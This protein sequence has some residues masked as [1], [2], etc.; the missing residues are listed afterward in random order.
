MLFVAL[1]VYAQEA[2]FNPAGKVEYTGG[3][4]TSTETIVA[5]WTTR[6]ASPNALSRSCVAYVTMGGS[7]YIYQ[8]G[9]GATTQL[10][11]VARYDVAANTWLNTG[12]ASIPFSMSS[13]AAVPVGDSSI[14]L[15]GGE[16]T[17]GLGKTCKYN[18]YTNTWTTMANMP[19]AVT[20]AAVV[21]WGTTK[22][23][24]IGGGTGLFGT[25]Y[26]NTVQVYDIATD[27]Y[28][29][30]GTYPVIAGMMGFGIYKD[31][32]YCAGGWDGAAAI[33]NA[34]KGVINPT[35]FQV[36]WTPLPNYPAGTCTRIAS[37]FV[38]KNT[39]GGILF[40]GGAIA[41]STVT[42]N[43]YLWDIC[44]GN[45]AT[46][47][48]LPLARSNMKAAG[49]GDS[50]A[51]VVC[52]YTTVGVGNNDRI[53][54]S[55]IDG[56]CITGGVAGALNPFNLQ[57]P[58]AGTTITTLPGSTT[59]VTSTWD[60]STAL[61]TYKWIFGSPTVPPR[62]FTVSAAT[63]MW[64]TTLGA[65]DAI[66]A[67]A[68]VNQGDSLIGQ[69]DVWA[70]RNNPPANDSLKAAN[71]PRA[72]I[73]KRARPALVAFNLV[74][75]ASGT[76]IVTSPF[77]SSMVSFLWRK[78]GA[79]VTYRWKFGSPTIGTV[80][81]NTLSNSSGFDTSLAGRKL[82]IDAILAGIGVSPGGSIAGQWAVWAYSGSDSLRSA[83]VFNVTFRRAAVVSLFSDDFSGGTGN[84]TITNDGGTCVW[85]TYSTPYPNTYT[86]PVTSSSPVFAADADDCGSSTTLLSTARLTTNLNCTNVQ[87]IA[88][89]FDNDWYIIDAQDVARVEVTT[90]GGTV[91]TSVWEYAGVSRRNSTETINLPTATNMPAVNVRFVS[92]QPGWDWWWAIDNVLIRGDAVVGVKESRPGVPTEYTLS[93]NYPNPFNPTTTISFG[94][95][96]AGLVTVKVF[97]LLGREV[98]T[99]LNE[100][101]PAGFYEV[102]LDAGLLSSGV[103][104]YRLQTNDFVATKKMILLK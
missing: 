2:D 69:W 83:A 4:G 20:D 47:P 12:F 88:L 62:R 96:R 98:A 44:N 33:A 32:I 76:E 103:Y 71:G 104:F 79:A 23:F 92:I 48:A 37:Y 86:L 38:K 40:S 16:S 51:Y 45:W 24:V 65:L 35:T 77:D 64:N 1:G 28:T 8:F 46:L 87:N 10:V 58:T 89:I 93:Q 75:P 91:W 61:A 72:I 68:G 66:L 27:T 85:Q 74:S 99:L 84:W 100:N 7:D 97:D 5:A 9:G 15:F 101:H 39:G 29:S 42:A 19:T 26:F 13:A 6:A 52:G 22:V 30:G 34:Y 70:F 102:Q 54:F 56:T 49:R 21:K 41:G 78:S 73:M 25:G 17:G 57:T 67:G 31:T 90:D 55:Q 59:P 14:Y 11:S 53:T 43:S 63:N 80:L 60:T 94:V 95:P 3:G 36:T 82:E 81:L 50:V 18:F